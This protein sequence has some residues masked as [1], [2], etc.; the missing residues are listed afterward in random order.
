MELEVLSNDTE[1]FAEQMR[2]IRYNHQD[3]E[4]ICHA[5]MDDLMCETLR[6]LGYEKGIDIFE[7]TP[8]WY[9]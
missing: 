1:S 8:K 7:E 2:V 4:E 6:S 9:A 5:L 3:D